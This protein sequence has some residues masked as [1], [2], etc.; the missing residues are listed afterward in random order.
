LTRSSTLSAAVRIST[1][2]APRARRRS[3][4]RPCSLGQAQVQDQQVELGVGQ[5]RGVGLAPLATWSTAAPDRAAA[6]QAIGQHLVVFGNQDAHGCLR[7]LRRGGR[8]EGNSSCAP[9]HQGPLA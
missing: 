5:Q 8:S 3:T 1:G 9:C 2:S 7:W 6:Q 4:S